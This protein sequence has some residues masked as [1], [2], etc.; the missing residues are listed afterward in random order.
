VPFILKNHSAGSAT[1]A[2]VSISVALFIGAGAGLG[3]M[4]LPT[5]GAHAQGFFSFWDDAPQV[6]KAKKPRPQQ[7]IKQDDDRTEVSLQEDRSIKGPLVLSVSIAKQRVTVYDGTDVVAQSPISSGRVGY[8]TPT[9][10]YTIVQKNRMHFS[11]LYENAPMP[12]MQRITW[13][14]VALHAGALPGYPASHGCIRLP[15]GF[16]KKLFGMTKMGQRVIVSREQAT[17]VEFS[18]ERLFKAYPPE[19]VMTTASI[20]TQVAD[21]SNSTHASVETV[22]HVLGVTAAAAAEPVN[23][24]PRSPYQIR[25][26]AE[27]AR[28]TGDIRTAG[29]KKEETSAELKQATKAADA[30]RA[31]YM[32][33]RPNIDKLDTAARKAESARDSAKRE[34]AAINERKQSKRKLSDSQA[35]KLDDKRASLEAKLPSLSAEADAARAEWQA[36]NDAAKSLETA[37]M[38]AEAARRAAFAEFSKANA[39]L[40]KALG[41]EDAIK[42][43]DAKRAYPVSVFI[44]RKTQRLYVRQGYEPIL[45]VPVTIDRADELIG[46]H[47]FTALDYVPHK[48][49]MSWT[50]VSIP[51]DGTKVDSKKSKKDKSAKVEAPKVVPA[52]QQTAASALERI[53]IPEDVRERIADV[54]KPGSSLIISDNGMSG[55]TGQYTDFIVSLR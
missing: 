32:Q 16:S 43:Q 52:S 31:P 53:T 48:T 2:A 1:G 3:V 47:V 10:V 36:A 29:Y 18:H 13:S 8:A 25:R 49:E 5:G 4:A 50:A 34:I 21:A 55:E 38:Q 17:P 12:N 19:G 26:E 27:L 46:T 39:A 42:R 11:N 37:M 45:D 24:L 6:R 33:V 15:H 28:I 22:S 20:E 14:G 30:A 41:E 44:S 35:R 40:S 51:T 23:S 54:M 7:A 9:G